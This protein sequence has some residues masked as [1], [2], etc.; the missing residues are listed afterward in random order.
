MASN[1]G[2]REAVRVKKRPDFQFPPIPNCHRLFSYT[3]P[4]RSDCGMLNMLGKRD[5]REKIK[6]Q[7][8]IKKRDKK[9]SGNPS[10]LGD[11]SC[12]EDFSTSELTGVFF[13]LG[14]RFILNSSLRLPGIE[15]SGNPSEFVI[16]PNW[17]IFPRANRP[18]FF[19]SIAA[20]LISNFQ[21]FKQNV[22]WLGK[23]REPE[24]VW[25]FLIF[26]RFSHERTDRCFFDFVFRFISNSFMKFLG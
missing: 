2:N 12:L 14:Y 22:T 4:Y 19:Y 1:I 13:G 10:E 23:L 21:R 18:V 15:K 5:F 17:R 8:G 20:N 6:N 9:N 7:R 24:R 16:F 26:R 3:T 25:R 11:F